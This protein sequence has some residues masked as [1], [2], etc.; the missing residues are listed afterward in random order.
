M[1]NMLK[2][3]ASKSSL[4]NIFNDIEKTLINHGAK[5]IIRDYKDGK[6]MAISFVITTKKGEMGI[7]LPARFDQVEQI[8]RNE[9]IKYKLEQPYRTAWATIRDWISAILFKK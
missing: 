9:G 2:N 7:R 5:Q 6:I 1:I 3:Y 8:F 4:P